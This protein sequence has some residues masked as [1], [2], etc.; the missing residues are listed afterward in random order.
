MKNI[1]ILILILSCIFSVQ[2]QDM[3]FSS[4]TDL[5]IINKDS[6]LGILYNYDVGYTPI[7]GLYIGAGPSI[8][9]SYSKNGSFFGIGCYG[10]VRYTAQ[11]NTQIKPFIDSRIIYSYSVYSKKGGVGYAVGVGAQLSENLYAGIH[12]VMSFDSYTTTTNEQ[13]ISGYT[14][15]F[16]IRTPQYSYRDVTNTV[17]TSSYTPM[18]TLGWII[19]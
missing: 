14:Y 6:T 7:D 2:A 17:K 11:L 8:S 10:K 9:T 15:V 5:G 3:G 13:Y 1:V 16:D 19:N 4:S 12:C 18:L